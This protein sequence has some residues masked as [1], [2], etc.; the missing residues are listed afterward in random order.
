[1]RLGDV[2]S[3]LAN[4]TMCQGFI[5]RPHAWGLYWTLQL[6]LVIYAACS[7][8]FSCGL[9]RR[10]GWTVGIV[11]VL[12]YLAAGVARPLALGKAYVVS[13]VRLLYFAPLV[14]LVARRYWAEQLS[15]RRFYL[16]L[17]SLPAALTVVWAVSAMRYREAANLLSLRPILCNWGLAYLCFAAL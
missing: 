1:I 17:V 16:F 12:G 10:V 2:G 15:A 11:L 9:L 5:G 3:W 7:L 4:L 14:G 13:D 8:L 6:E